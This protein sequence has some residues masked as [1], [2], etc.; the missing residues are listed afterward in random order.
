[1]EEQ[2]AR[3]LTR[4]AEAALAPRPPVDRAAHIGVHPQRQNGLNWIGVALTVGK[5]TAEQ[6]RGLAAIARDF[7]DGD[8]R[9]TVWQNLL[10]SGVPDGRIEA[11]KGAI[12]TLGLGWKASS[13]RAGLV[14][15]T[16]AAGC[17]FAAAHTKEHAV[18]IADYVDARLSLDTP[19]NVHLTGCHHSCA[20]HYVGDI[21]LMGAKVTINEEGDQVEGYTIVVGGGFADQAGIG[22]E[23]WRETPAEQCASKVEGLLRAYLDHRHQPTESFQAFTARYEPDELKALA[24]AME[25]A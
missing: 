7:G 13:L 15:C 25:T 2:L 10:I 3:P 14:A 6:M 19:V 1:V 11:V 17:K 8:I 22:R 5:M 16:G 21:G 23:L 4:I 9:L 20:Q 18:E 12:E 24:G